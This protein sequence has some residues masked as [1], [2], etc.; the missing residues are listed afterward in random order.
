MA[1]N[2]NRRCPQNRVL[3][4]PNCLGFLKF[5]ILNRNF[6]A[7]FAKTAKDSVAGDRPAEEQKAKG[8]GV[9]KERVDPAKIPVGPVQLLVQNGFEQGQNLPIQII[10]GGSEKQQG[11]DHPWWL[12]WSISLA[13]SG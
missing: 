2:N 1:K 3:S 8:L 10:D 11:A 7:K 5:R 9:L 13:S 12:D 4:R 6:N